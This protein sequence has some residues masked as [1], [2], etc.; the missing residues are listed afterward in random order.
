MNKLRR[1]TTL[2]ISTLATFLLA[3]SATASATP[4][5]S[6]TEAG[7]TLPP[8][9]AYIR[10]CESGNNYRAVGPMGAGGAYQ[11]TEQA[12]AI[13]GDSTW[14]YAEQAPRDAQDDAALK[15]YEA[16]GVNSW[17]ESKGCWGEKLKAK[18]SIVDPEVQE[19]AE[20]V[21]SALKQA[22]IKLKAEVGLFPS[23]GEKRKIH[24][25]AKNA[26]KPWSGPGSE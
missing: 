16:H 20:Q 5:T 22:I 3:P 24:V 26:S 14:R 10:E 6:P 18:A 21:V 4:M 19:Q 7:R 12:W 25:S 13:Y 9:L 11:F 8:V 1:P 2:A 23:G 15:R 17:L